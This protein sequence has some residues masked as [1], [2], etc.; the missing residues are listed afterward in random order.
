ME[1]KRKKRNLSLW[2]GGG[3]LI[4]F[5]TLAILGPWIA[6]YSVTDEDWSADPPLYPS[7]THW[8]GSDNQ[9][10][11]LLTLMLY[12]LKYTLF[13]SIGIA[14]LRILIGGVI[15][16]G[17]GMKEVQVK[18][19]GIFRVLGS[20]PVIIILSFL[21]T[22]VGITEDV[23][24]AKWELIVVQSVLM[25]LFGIAPIVISVKSKTEV[26][27]SHLFVMVAKQMGASTQ[28]VIWK[29]IFPLLKENLFL[30]F[31]Y[32]IILV[33]VMFGQ[34]SIVNVFLGGSLIKIS[35]SGPPKYYSKSQEWMSLLGQHKDYL[36]YKIWVIAYPLLGFFLLMLSFYLLYRG[37]E[38]KYQQEY[39]KQPYI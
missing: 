33:L 23:T 19:Q 2:I 29:H 27:K 15:G 24:P 22:K 17:L 38:K 30:M 18:Q 32:E 26:I 31:L 34:L 10:K 28:R 37:F 9:G 3:L 36:D 4:C 1:M 25:I 35:S 11:D 12:G 14:F 21:L 6:P 16:L 13:I 5:V 39:S 20:V 7:S 8:L